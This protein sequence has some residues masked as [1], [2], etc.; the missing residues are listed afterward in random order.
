MASLNPWLISA[1]PST[2]HPHTRIE[3]QLSGREWLRCRWDRVRGESQSQS[4]SQSQNP[5]QL[6]VEY[7]KGEVG[8]W[9]VGRSK[10]GWGVSH[11]PNNRC[12]ISAEFYEWSRVES[13]VCLYGTCIQHKH[14]AKVRHIHS[15]HVQNDMYIPIPFHIPP[16]VVLPVWRVAGRMRGRGWRCRRTR[17]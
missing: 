15:I 12:V 2:C 11:I 4:Q 3:R 17:W 16:L 5:R 13:R 8:M 9:G 6:V 14:V 1:G 10:R 7:D